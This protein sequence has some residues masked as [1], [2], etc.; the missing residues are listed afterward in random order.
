MIKLHVCQGPTCIKQDSKALAC[1]IE[2]LVA[3]GCEVTAGG[4]LNHCGKG[5]NIEVDKKGKKKVIEGVLNYKKAEQVV[6]GEAGIAVSGVMSTVANLKYDIRR[7]SDGLPKIDKALKALGGQD[8]GA[9]TQPRLTAELLVMRALASVKKDAEGAMRDGQRA[10]ELFPKFAPAHHAMAAAL[11]V[12]EKWPEATEALKK[13]L[14]MGGVA[15]DQRECY[16]LER[17]LKAKVE[18]SGKA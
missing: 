1:D 5:P 14:D 15:L 11:E 8:K 3:G 13:A 6:K 18:E 10:L 9:S 2:D 12:M 16:A 17:R 4:C 7:T